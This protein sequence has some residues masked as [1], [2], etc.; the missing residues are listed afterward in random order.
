MNSAHLHLVVNHVSFFA[1]VIGAIA[2]AIS[3]KRKSGDLR[4]LATSLFVVAG[5]FAWIAFATGEG[6][7]D[8]VEVL[9][10]GAKELI[11]QHEQ[12]AIWARRSGTLVALLALGLEWAVRKKKHWVK[13][14]QWAL[15]VFAL[16]GATV[17]MATAFLGGQIRHS[18]IR[19]EAPASAVK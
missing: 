1:V 8:I 4:G 17:Y 5:I 11:E 7:E 6:A 19:A 15:M 12:A 2:L 13:G 16:H 10:A 14:L 3:M 9:D 18:E